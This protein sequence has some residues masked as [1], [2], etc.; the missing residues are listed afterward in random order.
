[1][2]NITSSSSK[3]SIPIT[4][5]DTKQDVTSSIDR[6]GR[7]S[8]DERVAKRPRFAENNNVNDD[9][10]WRVSRSIPQTQCRPL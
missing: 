8:T 10:R 7:N 1:M 4:K 3:E 9:W 6:G 2:G 5:Q